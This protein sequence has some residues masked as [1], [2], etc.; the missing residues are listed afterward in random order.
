MLALNMNKFL[1]KLKVV[2]D[3]ILCIFVLVLPWP[4][5]RFFYTNWMGYDVDHEAY[6]GRS[7]ILSNYLKIGPN[8]SIASF[9]V[10]INL[11]KVI[12]DE[13]ASIGRGNWITGFPKN[14][15]KHFTHQQNRKPELLLGKHS[16]ITKNH[17]IDCTDSIIIG[18]FSTVAGY[19]SQFLTHSIDIY[20]CR[21]DSKPI[22]IGNYCF[23]GTGCII[24]GGSGLPD[25]SVLGAGSLLQ[26]DFDE[27]FSL[28]A[29]APAKRI[30]KIDPAAKYFHRLAGFIH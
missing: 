10:I 24:L 19:N 8:S 15:K 12:M 5:R 29:G 13:S 2:I 14:S 25:N 21:Q 6:I 26:K 18:D 3:K 30:K 22:N 28:Y 27:T 16:A 9:N 4:V 11:E 1:R 20:E 7:I 23:I 17:H